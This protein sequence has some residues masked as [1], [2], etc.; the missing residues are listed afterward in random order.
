M[1]WCI[2][3]LESSSLPTKTAIPNKV[4]FENLWKNES[5]DINT[6]KTIHDKQTSIM[7]K[8]WRYIIQ[9][10][11]NKSVFGEPFRAQERL[12]AMEVKQEWWGYL[13]LRTIF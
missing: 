4:I 12:H 5:F 6:I 13:L 11:S 9:W 10:E 2:S 8:S 1:K 7:K 3:V